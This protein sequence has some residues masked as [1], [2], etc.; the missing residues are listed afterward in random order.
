LAQL[1]PC[2]E[3]NFAQ[4]HSPFAEAART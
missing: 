4:E 3:A 1:L 2:G